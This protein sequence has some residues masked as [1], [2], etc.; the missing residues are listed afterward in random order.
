M[1]CMTSYTPVCSF[2]FSKRRLPVSCSTDIRHV[3]P[4][5]RLAAVRRVPEKDV[6]SVVKDAAVTSCCDVGDST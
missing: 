1:L 2:S 5:S 6:F 4:I 3:F